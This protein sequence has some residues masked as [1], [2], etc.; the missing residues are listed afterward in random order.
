MRGAHI[1]I[2]D[3]DHGSLG[4]LSDNLRSYP[5]VVVSHTTGARQAYN[6][7][8]GHLF[9]DI[10]VVNTTA[11]FLRDCLSEPYLPLPRSPMTSALEL[12]ELW[13]RPVI[14]CE[15]EADGNALQKLR[16]EYDPQGLI[17]ASRRTALAEIAFLTRVLPGLRPIILPR[18]PFDP[19]HAWARQGTKEIIQ[20][21]RT[22]VGVSENLR[23]TFESFL[24][25][26]DARRAI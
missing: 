22:I 4:D 5:D 10:A 3:G 21:E 6:H 8:A 13:K 18:E 1:L 2:M 9:T 12:R 16:G 20:P 24:A 25:G 11:N 7:L 23:P 15:P 17:A 26:K 19:A 14:L